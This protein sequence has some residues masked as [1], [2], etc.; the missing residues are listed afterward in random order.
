[1]LVGERDDEAVE[2]IGLEL[3]A[4]CLQAV[5]I[6]GHRRY[7]SPRDSRNKLWHWVRFSGIPY[8]PLRPVV[9]RRAMIRPN[10]LGESTI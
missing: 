4:K 7:L 2:L 8:L 3:L 5:C 10:V 9:A 1:M 6:A